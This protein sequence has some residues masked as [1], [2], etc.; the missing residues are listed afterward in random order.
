MLL[1]VSRG[2]LAT[3]MFLGMS[4]VPVSPGRSRSVAPTRPQTISDEQGRGPRTSRAPV[5]AAPLTHESL[6]W[7]LLL[8]ASVS[9]D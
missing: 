2:T 3:G 5:P 1:D 8:Q 7:L 6:G 4:Q 9:A